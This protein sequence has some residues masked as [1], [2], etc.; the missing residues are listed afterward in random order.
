MTEL[1]TSFNRLDS[2]V[3]AL[4]QLTLRGTSGGAGATV[5]P[6]TGD[7]VLEDQLDWSPNPTGWEPFSTV[8]PLVQDAAGEWT[9]GEL[10]TDYG[11]PEAHLVGSMCVLTGLVRRKVGA[12]P[13][14]MSA[15]TR[16]SSAMFGL[17]S[18]MRPTN[19]VVLPCLMGNTDPLTGGV[20]YIA[21]VEVRPEVDVER[22]SGR[23][24]FI[25][26]T[27]SLTPGTGYIALQGVFPCETIQT[28]DE[29]IEEE[30]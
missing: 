12:T 4:E 14:P 9:G 17:P 11:R 26:G 27:G 1:G 7:A 2:R 21:W 25:S 22:P 23:V 20:T 18:G 8:S 6:E 15:G 19:R 28:D 29:A 16:Y 13:N 24:Y 5:D 30:V 10:S 3:S